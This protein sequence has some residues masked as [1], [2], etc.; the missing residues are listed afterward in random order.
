MQSN[1]FSKLNYNETMTLKDDLI[2][3]RAHWQAV[4]EIEQEEQRTTSIETKWLQLNSI[5]SLAIRWGIFKPDPSENVVYIQWAKLKEK[6]D[7]QPQ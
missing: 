3:Y 7:L 2:A 6:A 4:A 1:L 5:I